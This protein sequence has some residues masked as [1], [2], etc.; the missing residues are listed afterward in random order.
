MKAPKVS[1]KTKYRAF[2]RQKAGH[3]NDHTVIG[4]PT[5]NRAIS[6]PHYQG[7]RSSTTC[8]VAVLIVEILDLD[9]GSNNCSQQHKPQRSPL[10]HFCSRL[11]ACYL[12]RSCSKGHITSGIQDV[13][14]H[15]AVIGGS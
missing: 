5:E 1:G 6:S 11:D 13:P 9:C 8:A 4:T 7:Q 3:K 10:L 2:K 14:R 12:C 15:I